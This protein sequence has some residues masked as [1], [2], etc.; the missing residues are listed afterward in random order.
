MPLE[1]EAPFAFCFIVSCLAG[2]NPV[3]ICLNDLPQPQCESLSSSPKTHQSG[4]LLSFSA[5]P[6]D[7]PHEFAQAELVLGV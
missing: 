6:L 2:V 1:I 7:A 4:Y 5:D 3:G